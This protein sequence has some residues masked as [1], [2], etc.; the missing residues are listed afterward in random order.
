M[1]TWPVNERCLASESSRRVLSAG[2]ASAT[3]IAPRAETASIGA[4]N[5][6]ESVFIHRG[7]RDHDGPIP[8]FKPVPA[9]R[10][11]FPADQPYSAPAPDPVHRLVQPDRAAA[12]ARPVDRDLALLL[13]P[14]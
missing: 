11:Q 9:G 3:A 7:L 1:R 13:R 12:G 4:P 2:S 10:A 14:R 5:S 6:I 8:D